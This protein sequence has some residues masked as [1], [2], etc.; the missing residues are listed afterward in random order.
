MASLLA[1]KDTTSKR[2]LQ[3]Q[4]S[5]IM[6]ICGTKVQ[7][8][9]APKT[10]YS[11]L[12]EKSKFARTFFLCVHVTNRRVFIVNHNEKS[13]KTFQDLRAKLAEKGTPKARGRLSHI[14]RLHR[15]D[16]SLSMVTLKY[17]QK[18]QSKIENYRFDMKEQYFEVVLTAVIT[19]KTKRYLY[20]MNLSHILSLIRVL[21]LDDFDEV[22]D[23]PAEE[24][25]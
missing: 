24:E 3:Q 9:I 16:S 1:L 23:E 8:Y 15:R 20:N 2:V 10:I 7:K 14:R 5:H 17:L 22:T 18:L 25:E 19:G 6:G 12:K 13:R 21:R 4:A 11:V